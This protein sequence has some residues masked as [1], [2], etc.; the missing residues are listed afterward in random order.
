MR[1]A[2][3][4][5]TGFVGGHLARV[6][7][8]ERH[9]VVLIAR[10]ADRRDDTI[11]RLNHATFRAVGT[12][13]EDQLAAA[14]AGCDAVAHC[15]G[16]NREIGAQTYARVHVQGTRHVVNAARRAGVKKIVLV[17]FLR[18]RPDCG[19]G[20]HESKFAAEEMVRGSGLDYTVLKPGVIYGRGDHML[21][22][23]SHAFFTFPIF[24]FVGF[25]PKLVRPLAVADFVRVLRAALVDGR[26]SRQTVAVTG[27]D[28]MPLTEA[29]RRVARAVGKRPLMVP[30]PLWFH[31]AFG[32]FCEQTMR[33]PLISVA[34]V[35]IL[36]EGVVE[37]LPPCDDVP[38]DLK[39]RL[40]FSAQQIG[41]GLPE[42]KPFGPADCRCFTFRTRRA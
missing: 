7:A 18:A 11:R 2:I 32:W 17:S 36:S 42:P 28:E 10:G 24:G 34:Q 40:P 15:A 14:F 25:A 29:V 37:P 38:D 19:A 26:L 1:I 9:D 8:A 30:L 5:G 21:D 13:D 20:Y 22:H 4:G 12:G 39:P 31:Y 6:L 33:I 41:A 16:I 23:L 35:R 3:T 27:P